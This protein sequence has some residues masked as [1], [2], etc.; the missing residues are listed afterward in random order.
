MKQMSRR[1]KLIA[2]VGPNASGKTSLA[3]KLAKKFEG[4]II[5]ADSRQ[6]FRGMDIGTGKASKKEQ[7]Q[8]R[9][10]LLDVAWPKQ[11]YNVSH[12]KKDA[13]K[14]INNVQQKNKIPFLVGG[15][16]FW[17]QAV[18]D[19]I[20]FPAIKP[21]YRL[22]TKLEKFPAKKLFTMLE[23]LDPQRAKK[24]DQHNPYRLIRAIEIISATK[25]SITPLH[26]KPLY[27]VLYIGL[28]PPRQKL[29]NLIDTRLA[30]R[31]KK[32]MITEVQKLRR[33]GV[34][35]RRLYNFGLEYRFISLYL[36]KKLTREQMIERL[37]YA[38]HHYAKR[39]MTWFR[40]DKRI[41]WIKNQ[42]QAHRLIKK[43][44]I[45]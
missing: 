13:L 26:T 42:A 33:N 17:I 18:V 44:L 37:T 1:P 29:Y 5:S 19:N 20:D 41:H 40:R 8:I 34:S 28:N 38:I 12:Y 23:K 22:R 31:F 35:W 7:K 45:Q 14:A 11:E 30:Q 2:I 9:H 43:F 10:Y 27:D 15:T 16:G 6:V 32:G 25:K 39:Q 21:N 3:I 4:E 36:Q 24:I